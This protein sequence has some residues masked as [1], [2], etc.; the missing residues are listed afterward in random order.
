VHLNGRLSRGGTLNHS[1]KRT[2]KRQLSSQ[3][4]LVY[5]HSPW[6]KRVSSVRI[7]LSTFNKERVVQNSVGGEVGIAVPFVTYSFHFPSIVYT[8]VVS[9][10]LMLLNSVQVLKP[11][12]NS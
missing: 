1:V 8:K 3:R 7:A 4:I 5:Q 10:E 11:W 6:N 12:N 2:I 9:I